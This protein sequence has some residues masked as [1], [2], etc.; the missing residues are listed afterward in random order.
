VEKG[1]RT[2]TERSRNGKE[3]QKGGGGGR[4]SAEKSMYREYIEDGK[5]RKLQV[6]LM[7]RKHFYGAMHFNNSR[8]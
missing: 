6:V 3:Q 5:G 8:S 4:R 7:K 1:H 2:C